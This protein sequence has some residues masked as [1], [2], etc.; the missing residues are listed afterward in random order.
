MILRSVPGQLMALSKTRIIATPRKRI[1]VC[2]IEARKVRTQEEEK[3]KN[4]FRDTLLHFIKPILGVFML[5]F[6]VN[7]LSMAT[8]LYVMSVYDKVVGAKAPATLFSLLAIIVATVGFELYLRNRRSKII[9]YVGARFHNLL[10]NKAL[11]RLLGLP[12]Q[13]V[14]NV[15]VGSQIMRFRQ[16][17]TI[18]AF[19]T[20][21]IVSAMLDLPFTLLFVAL[22][23]FIGGSLALIPVT[24]ALLFALMALFTVPTTK[25]NTVAGGKARNRAGTF[26]EETLDKIFAI[27]QLHAENQ[28]HHRFASFVRDDTILRFK[29]RFYDGMMHTLS[30]SLVMVS[31]IATLGIGAMLVINGDL[32][33]GALIALMMVV[34]RILSPIQTTFLSL[35]R[36][37]QFGETVQQ[38]NGM[39]RLP[40]ERRVVVRNR[41]HSPLAG[42]VSLNGVSFRH[43]PTVEAA[44]R[45][46]SFDINAGEVVAISGGTG[47]G[48]TTITKLI[49]GLYQPQA[50]TILL[51]GL[52]LRQLDVSEIRT[53]I[54]Y[55]PQTP[56]LFYGT[57]RQNLVLAK[58]D[59]AEDDIQFALIEAGIDLNSAVFP[60]GLDTVLRN[61]GQH[62]SDGL[63]MK[64]CLARAYLKRSHLYL[65]DDPGAYLDPEGDQAL[66]KFMDKLRSQVTI[67]LVTNRPGLMRSADRV[68]KLD[69][70]MLVADGSPEEVLKSIA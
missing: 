35:N 41:L 7:L 38:I 55:V 9:A 39:M 65:L 24:L 14:E 2:L 44:V 53:G 66:Q 19:F 70:G 25:R 11:E 36:I 20:G 13:M 47:A 69:A 58:P 33:V 61:N 62:L 59:V 30:Q 28:W 6:V 57:V 18:R 5:T 26:I 23:F 3:P 63:R 15:A 50:G 45:N 49:S 60:D 32:S 37:T 16:L 31:G 67:I 43:G 48:K 21:H 1:Q 56:H 12:I 4:W 46:L 64:L 51:D 68:L 8:P 52:N 42:Q 34:W 54:G 10:T 27:R 17:D 29:A 22:I 40:M